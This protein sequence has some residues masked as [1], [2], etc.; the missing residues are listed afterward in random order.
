MSRLNAIERQAREFRVRAWALYAADVCYRLL[1]AD[2]R[3][4]TSLDAVG[5]VTPIRGGIAEHPERIAQ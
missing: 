5:K 4:R 3:R 1:R 2:A